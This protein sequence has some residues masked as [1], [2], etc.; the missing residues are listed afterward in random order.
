[1]NYSIV[2][3]TF[4]NKEILENTLLSIDNLI[5]PRESSFEVVVAD[6]GSTDG[7]FEML[8]NPKQNYILKSVFIKRDKLSSRARARNKALELASGDII[9]FIDSDILLRPTYLL[10]LEKIYSFSKN[11]EC[12]EKLIVSGFRTLIK[13]NIKKEWVK[14][15]KIFGRDFLNNLKTEEDFRHVILNDIS[16]NAAACKAPFIYSITCNLAVPK[17]V[18]DSVGG[19]CEKYL[20]WGMEDVELMHRIKNK[21]ATI[22][23]NSREDVLHQNHT[24][25]DLKEEVKIRNKDTKTN[26]DIFLKDYPNFMGLSEERTRKLFSNLALYYSIVEGKNDRSKVMIEFNKPTEYFD[27]KRLIE[28]YKNYENT[29]ICIYDSCYKSDIDLE[30]QLMEKTK[31][32]ICYYPLKFKEKIEDQSLWGSEIDEKV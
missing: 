8:R 19:F 14:S 24:M 3:P 22:I 12:N 1:M 5:V 18:V 17:K 20:C 23:F 32:R 21:G 25:V 15:G 26:L 31:A 30:I 16:Y 11:Y 13:Q 28:N 7:T 27:V 10:T 4:D 2:I 29:D 6:D 9:V